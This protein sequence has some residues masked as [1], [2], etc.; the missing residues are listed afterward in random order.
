MTEQKTVTIKGVVYDIATGQPVSRPSV[1][2]AKARVKTNSSRLT[3]RPSRS[4]T[5]RSQPASNT[6][7]S[8]SK[9]GPKPKPAAKPTQ[10]SID[11]AAMSHPAVTKAYA[12]AQAKGQKRAPK[13]S[14]VIKN[15]AIKDAL[16]RAPSKARRPLKL[17]KQRSKVTKFTRTATAALAL[18]LL[19]G[20]LTYLNMPAVSTQ[21][22]ASQAGINAKYP[23]YSPTGYNLSGPVTYDSGMVKM[24]FAANAGPQGYT[25]TEERSNWDSTAVRENQVQPSVGQDYDTIQANGLT[26]YTYAQNATW[27]SGG[28]LYTITGDAKLSPTQ[29]QRIAVSM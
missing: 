11:I 4:A 20:Y 7:P 12:A 18:V 23:S 3:S 21:I 8:V 16:D 14:A 25:I 6:H 29:V 15:E 13:P 1:Q 27:V 19:G 26:I 9:F 10:K 22:A 2:P 28:I 5:L 17:K 24:K